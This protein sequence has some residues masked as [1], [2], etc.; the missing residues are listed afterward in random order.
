MAATTKI[1]NPKMSGALLAS[2]WKESPRHFLQLIWNQLIS[3]TALG[4]TFQ[5]T[6]S[7]VGCQE[8]GHTESLKN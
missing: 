1:A 4:P 3:V 2:L 8:K 6:P 7:V 5:L